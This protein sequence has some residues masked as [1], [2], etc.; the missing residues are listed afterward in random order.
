MINFRTN[1]KW[2]LLTKAEVEIELSNDETFIL[3]STYGR[4]IEF[5]LTYN[6]IRIDFNVSS[7]RFLKTTYSAF[8][9]NKNFLT[10]NSGIFDTVEINNKIYKMKGIFSSHIKE[11]RFYCKPKPFLIGHDYVGSF[12]EEFKL[13]G[14]TIASYILLE[15]WLKKG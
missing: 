14:L 6:N 3:T 8:K 5:K 7:K 13:A 11:L 10:I 15:R 1:T 12:S 9:D 4:M 2:P